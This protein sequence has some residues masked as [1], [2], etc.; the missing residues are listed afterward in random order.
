MTIGMIALTLAAGAQVSSSFPV[1][2]GTRE[3]AALLKELNAQVDPERL[4]LLVNDRRADLLARQIAQ[5]S[6][7]DDR[8]RLRGLAA[9][10]LINAGRNQDALKALE[11]LEEE[12]RA[13]DPQGWSEYQSGARLL[14]AMAWLRLGEEQNCE[15]AHNRDSCL[16]PIAGQGV[17]QRTE[18]SG[19]A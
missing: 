14:Q 1:A 5:A 9:V 2:P 4:A 16:L 11:V 13:V 8:L 17:H 18:G 10:E 12:A 6:Q 7:P 19:R 15:A 3:M